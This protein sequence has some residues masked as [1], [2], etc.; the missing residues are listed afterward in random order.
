MDALVLDIAVQIMIALSMALLAW[1]G[2]LCLGVLRE[3]S[4]GA[5]ERAEARFS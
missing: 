5:A 1:G 4:T 3:R 2:C